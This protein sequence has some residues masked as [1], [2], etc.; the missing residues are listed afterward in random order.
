MCI[1]QAQ[2]P[3]ARG[4][5]C[6]SPEL[7]PPPPPLGFPG[8]SEVKAL[9]LQCGRPGFNPWVRKIPWKWKWHPTPVFLPG[10]SHG[11]RSLVGY[12]PRARKE[13]DTAER[14]HF[15][16][17]PPLVH[18]EVVSISAREQ[19]NL[20][21]ARIQ[22]D[23]NSGT[24]ELSPPAQHLLTSILTVKVNQRYFPLLW[25]IQSNMRYPHLLYH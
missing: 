14:L 18:Q 10:E 6:S 20:L 17:P 15:Q 1:T 21:I 2:K 5:S 16:F 22:G 23:S 3:A 9:C 25:C 4:S 24:E 13:S 11:W 19:S 12:S 7:V 8:S